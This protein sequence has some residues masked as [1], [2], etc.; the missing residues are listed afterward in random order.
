MVSVFRLISDELDNFWRDFEIK[1]DQSF[2][3]LHVAIQNNLCYD[4]SQ[5]A[6]FFLCE[7]NWEKL[8][9]ITLVG[10]SDEESHKLLFMDKETIQ[11]HVRDLKQKLLYVYDFFN[12]R[13]FFIELKEIREE[14]GTA[15]YPFCSSGKGNPPQQILM[16]QIFIDKDLGFDLEEFDISLD[17]DFLDSDF[18]DME[19]F[20]TLGL[21]SPDLDDSI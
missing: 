19:G 11:D 16:D 14:A 5:I 7:D 10:I 6:S 1:S 4:K 3:D 13:A 15:T 18:L 2:Y 12:E 8:Q 20:E 21:D 9:E 17:S